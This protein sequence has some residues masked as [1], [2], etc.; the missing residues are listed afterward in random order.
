MGGGHNSPVSTVLDAGKQQQPNEKPAANESW[1]HHTI[2][3][4]DTTDCSSNISPSSS[5]YS[6]FSDT[7]PVLQPSTLDLTNRTT[8]PPISYVPN[9]KALVNVDLCSSPARTPA[10]H[11]NKD[12]YSS[13]KAYMECL[14]P[15]SLKCV[16]VGDS[17]VGKTSLLTNYTTETFV[18]QHSPTIYDKFISKYR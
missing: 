7:S 14:S 16:L 15:Q 5:S 17:G 11:Q 4:S 13:V 9:S 18:K 10:H 8:S 6:T 3:L 1:Q 12:Q 2:S